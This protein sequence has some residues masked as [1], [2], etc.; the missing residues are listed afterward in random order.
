MASL[1]SLK[2]PKLLSK[3]TQKDI[4]NDE[5]DVLIDST[6]VPTSSSD[7]VM[8]EVKDKPSFTPASAS[9]EKVRKKEWL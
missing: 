9:E 4:Q 7:V 1:E 6:A 8:E 3:K 2:A 5:D